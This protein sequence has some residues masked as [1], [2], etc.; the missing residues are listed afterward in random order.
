MQILRLIFQQLLLSIA[1]EPHYYRE[2]PVIEK[3]KSTEQVSKEEL[4]YFEQEV[5]D[6]EEKANRLA[7]F[8]RK[9]ES[10]K[11]QKVLKDQVSFEFEKKRIF[12]EEAESKNEEI[13][14]KNPEVTQEKDESPSKKKKDEI[15]FVIS[16]KWTGL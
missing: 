4:Q 3:Q 14:N 5:P 12:P 11:A 13:D 8:K 9:E 2:D 1:N 15:E 7:L 6:E 16:T 10:K